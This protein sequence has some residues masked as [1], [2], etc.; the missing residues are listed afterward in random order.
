MCAVFFFKKVNTLFEMF[1]SDDVRAP[2]RCSGAFPE[3]ARFQVAMERIETQGEI[4]Q[5]KFEA[6]YHCAITSDRIG[7]HTVTDHIRLG[8]DGSLGVALS[9]ALRA[10]PPSQTQT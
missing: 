3:P 2:A 4:A 5:R 7:A 10:R 6:F 9:Q 8:G 1:V